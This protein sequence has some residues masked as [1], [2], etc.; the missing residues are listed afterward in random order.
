MTIELKIF[1]NPSE[2]RKMAQEPFSCCEYSY[3]TNGHI[4]VRIEKQSDVPEKDFSKEMA[5]LFEEFTTENMVEF[6][7]DIPLSKV[8][9][10]KD[11]GGSGDGDC[12]CPTCTCECL[13]CRGTGKITEM[14]SIQI[15]ET[16]F[17]SKYIRLIKSLPEL[18]ISPAK[19]APSSFVFKGGIGLLM[20]IIG[21]FKKHMVAKI[22]AV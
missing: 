9:A 17:D 18:K 16:N 3:A 14:I 22:N 2:K 15:G 13:G 11:C 5:K 1:C 21:E 10:C 12:D 4:C 20:P 6:D 8:E 19:N 7:I